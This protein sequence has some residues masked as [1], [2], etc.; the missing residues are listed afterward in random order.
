MQSLSDTQP[1]ALKLPNSKITDS[2]YNS[3]RTLG[4]GSHGSSEP[5]SGVG[6]DVAQYTPDIE[7]A[8][9]IRSN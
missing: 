7:H 6:Y 9:R 5:C 8:Y 2:E 1:G 4:A 3:T